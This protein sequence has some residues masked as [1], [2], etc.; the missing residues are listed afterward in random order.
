MTEARDTRLLDE[1]RAALDRNAGPPAGRF[2]G[3]LSFAS[4]ASADD[5]AL[6][7]LLDPPVAEPAGVRGSGHTDRALAFEVGDGSLA[8]EV[9]VAHD[10]LDGQVL[11]GDPAEVVLERVG[12]PALARP[13][14][15]LGRF[16]FVRT[17][18]GSCRLRLSG[19]PTGPVTTDWFLLF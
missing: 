10:R 9:V 8:V 7:E 18:P 17:I 3:L 19:G 16:T 15:D 2:D 6:A 13:V 12:G 5:D 1:L 11:V 14:D 4:F